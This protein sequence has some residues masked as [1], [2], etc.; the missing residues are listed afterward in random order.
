[1][2]SPNV[3][4]KENNKKYNIILGQIC[5]QFRMRNYTERNTVTTKLHSISIQVSKKLETFVL[6]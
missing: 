6:K 1:M 2:T 4:N 5:N 3:T